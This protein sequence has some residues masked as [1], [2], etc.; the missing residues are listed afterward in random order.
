MDWKRE[1]PESGSEP[2]RA[3]L[4][5]YGH[6]VAG[7]VHGHEPVEPAQESPPDEDRRERA[8]AVDEP[9]EVRLG[10]ELVHGGVDAEPLQQALHDV[11]EAAAAPAH[12][13]HGAL[14]NR[15]PHL[16][17]H[18][19]RRQLPLLRCDG[20]KNNS[21]LLRPRPAGAVRDGLVHSLCLGRTGSSLGAFSSPV[22]SLR[23]AS[24]WELRLRVA[25]DGAGPQEAS[26]YKEP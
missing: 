4:L 23:F 19:R 6:E 9:R 10:G 24:R 5:E 12:H 3:G 15:A 7:D 8:A 16:L 20:V 21:R 18:R 11:A 14:R 13:E 17:L 22:G 26:I 25:R 1:E 2:E